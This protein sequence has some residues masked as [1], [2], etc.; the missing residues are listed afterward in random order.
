[1]PSHVLPLIRYPDNVHEFVQPAG[2][3]LY[4]PSGMWHA[5]WNLDDSVA[6]THN[7]V[8]MHTWKEI[9]TNLSNI[10]D[11]N[12]A[13]RDGDESVDRRTRVAMLLDEYFGLDNLPATI[14]WVEAIAQLNPSAIITE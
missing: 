2:S 9:Y 6:V 3:L 12:M 1:M 11:E 7:Y 5:V 4:V 14:S 10:D 13:T 8:A